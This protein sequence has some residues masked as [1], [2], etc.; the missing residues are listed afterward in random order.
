MSNLGF[1]YLFRTYFISVD[2]THVPITG[3]EGS[4]KPARTNE[5]SSLFL[6]GFAV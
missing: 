6:T 3:A 2:L 4:Y 5:I 1:F